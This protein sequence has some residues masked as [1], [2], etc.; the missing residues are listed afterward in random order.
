MT[1]CSSSGEIRPADLVCH[2]GRRYRYVRRRWRILFGLIDCVGYTAWGVAF[3]IRWLFFR[4]KSSS[5]SIA[6]RILIVQLDHL[7][8]AVI[9]STMLPALRARFPRASIDVLASRRCREWFEACPDVARVHV[10]RFDRFDRPACGFW[11]LVLLAWGIVL[12]RERYDVAIDPR[13]EFPHA[14]LLWLAGA[15]RRVGWSCGGGGFLLTDVPSYVPGRSEYESRQ[16]LLTKLEIDVVPAAPAIEPGPFARRTIDSELQA[17][18]GAAHQVIVLHVGAGTAAKQW[19]VEHWR[20]LIGRLLV[21][22]DARLVLVGGAAERRLAREITEGNCWPGVVDWT[23][24]LSLRELAALFM[25]ADL[26]VGA[27]S[28]PAHLAAAVR[29]PVVVLFSGT[30]DAGQWAPRGPRVAVLRQPVEC[31]PCHRTR[32]P[33]VDHACMQEL[34]PELVLREVAQFCYDPARDSV[35]QWLDLTSLSPSVPTDR[36]RVSRENGT[37]L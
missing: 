1:N 26:V 27:D 17:I 7:G 18:R 29:T 37:T 2:G 34:T 19:P 10:C 20:E 30:N 12:R 24:C 9:T 13:G 31:S 16:A 4:T 33:L 5:E 22:Y 32:C 28:G 35:G 8:D 3:A 11:M 21:A 6:E 25:R 36:T 23:G 14:L 15:R